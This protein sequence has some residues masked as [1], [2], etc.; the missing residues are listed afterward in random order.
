[1]SL[2]YNDAPSKV[3][4]KLLFNCGRQEKLSI[5]TS[6]TLSTTHAWHLC[7]QHSFGLPIKRKE[8]IASNFLSIFFCENKYTVT[9]YESGISLVGVYER[10]GKICHF[11]LKMVYRCIL[12]LSKSQE[13]VLVLFIYS[14]SQ[15][16]A[17]TAVKWNAMF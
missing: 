3:L 14:F 9:W 1:M 7:C 10:G 8:K 12:W 16:S 4:F 2:V 11:G 15:D 13:N 5:L 17:L 6:W